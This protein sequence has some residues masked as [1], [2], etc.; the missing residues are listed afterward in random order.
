[1]HPSIPKGLF[2]RM[3][4]PLFWILQAL[5]TISLTIRT[6]SR[7]NNLSK[8]PIKVTLIAEATVMSDAGHQAIR[9]TEQTT[10]LLDA[11]AAYVLSWRN[12]KGLFEVPAKR[13]H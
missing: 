8:N 10:G 12:M 4:A 1:M 2:Y 6:W 13:A 3:V 7:M 11:V 5:T 9:L